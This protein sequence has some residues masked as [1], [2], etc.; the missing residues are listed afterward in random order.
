MACI[1]IGDLKCEDKNDT[2]ERHDFDFTVLDINQFA[3]TAESF[4]VDNRRR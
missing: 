1:P 3:M 4:A 2:G